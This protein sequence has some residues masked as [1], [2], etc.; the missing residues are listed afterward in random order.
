[1]VV[2]WQDAA[3]YPDLRR[4]QS[5]VEHDR[6]ALGAVHQGGLPDRLQL[7]VRRR[8]QHVHVCHGERQSQRGQLHDHLLPRAAREACRRRPRRRS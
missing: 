1:V 7:R 6:P 3:L 2:Q 4:D 8:H 5:V